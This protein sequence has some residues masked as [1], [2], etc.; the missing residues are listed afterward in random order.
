[1]KERA[2]RLLHVEHPSIVPFLDYDVRDE[3]PVFVTPWLPHNLRTAIQ[4]GETDFIPI[5]SGQQLLKG[6]PSDQIP[7]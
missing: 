2:P 6:T 1:M 3:E 4:N 5:V 7:P